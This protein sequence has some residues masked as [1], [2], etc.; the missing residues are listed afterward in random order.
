MHY[1][2]GT[3]VH[4][5]IDAWQTL[6]VHSPGG[7]TLCEMTSWLPRDIES[8]ISQEEHSSR[9]SLQSDLKRWLLMLFS[10]GCPNKKK[11]SS[12][13]RSVPDLKIIKHED[14]MN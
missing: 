10:R 5:C 4:C 8:K 1:K 14:S 3:G 9:I 7:S 11:M 13:I 12:N 2:S 6:P